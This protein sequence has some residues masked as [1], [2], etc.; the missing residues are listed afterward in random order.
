MT[1]EYE[2]QGE[3][4][5]QLLADELIIAFNW[6]P[7]TPEYRTRL[8][9]IEGGVLVRADDITPKVEIDAIVAAHDPNGLTSDEIIENVLIGSEAEVQNVPGWAA[10]STVSANDWFSTNV[11]SLLSEIPNVD[12]LSP[13]QFQN[14]AQAIVA[15]MQDIITNQAN[16]IKALGQMVIALRNKTWPNL[17]E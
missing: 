11:E 13:T 15:Q 7:I 8:G 2:Y 6:N 14:N 10:W 5:L 4:R 1:V 17:Q 9:I 16:V 3:F 12:G